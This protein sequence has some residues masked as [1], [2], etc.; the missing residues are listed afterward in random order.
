MVKKYEIIKECRWCEV[1]HTFE[2]DEYYFSMRIGTE[3]KLI[4]EAYTG[5]KDEVM[6]NYCPMCGKKL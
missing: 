3:G 1:G 4:V 6:I 2:T 5:K